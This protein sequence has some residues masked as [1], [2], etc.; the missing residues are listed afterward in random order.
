MDSSVGR[1][2]LDF[3]TEK[4]PGTGIGASNR[5]R[6]NR[7]D[8]GSGSDRGGALGL[9]PV[10]GL[11]IERRARARTSSRPRGSGR[12]SPRAPWW[13]L[14]PMLSAERLARAAV[15]VHVGHD[16]LEHARAVE[17]RGAEPGGM[18]AR[19]DDSRDCPRATR[20]RT[21]SRSANTKPRDPPS[22]DFG[23]CCCPNER[24]RPRRVNGGRAHRSM[25][26]ADR[27]RG[28]S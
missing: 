27:W 1:R 16:A 2:K 5:E 18:R 6:Q 21:R 7:V 28:N 17:H 15:T 24:L 3:M 9:A 13:A 23:Q 4:P 19:A 20:R 22:T 12:R 8:S 11:H 14:R 25:K 10:H 26:D